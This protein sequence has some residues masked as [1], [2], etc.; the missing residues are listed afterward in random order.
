MLDT[1]VFKALIEIAL[2]IFE[3]IVVYM[4]LTLNMYERV[5]PTCS[6][7]GTAVV[8]FCMCDTKLYNTGDSG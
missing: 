8:P 5:A 7:G 3:A 1:F 6:F 2:F 4:L